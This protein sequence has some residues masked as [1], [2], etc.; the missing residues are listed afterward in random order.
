MTDTDDL[1]NEGEQLAREWKARWKVAEAER[2]E[3][4]DRNHAFE[5]VLTASLERFKIEASE[6]PDR[7]ATPLEDLLGIDPNNLADRLAGR[8]VQYREQRDDLARRLEAV[9]ERVE[10]H[11]SAATHESGLSFVLDDVLDFINAPLPKREED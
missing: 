11:L 10:F 2:D 9:R 1:L 6:H 8:A 7:E 3:A 5:M 4:R